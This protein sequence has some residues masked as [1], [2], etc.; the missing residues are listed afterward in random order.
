MNVICDYCGKP[1][2]LVDSTI[3]YGKS[4]GKIYYCARC[5]AWVSCYKNSDRP[6]GRL[7][8]AELR[9]C[10][11]I[12]YAALR[13]FRRNSRKDKKQ[14]RKWLSK[15]LHIPC[16]ET[17]IGLF[18]VEQCRRMIALCKAFKNEEVNVNGNPCSDP[19]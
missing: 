1:A 12:A 18:D 16:A 5:G 7:A 6:S 15:R 19:R 13:D 10:R 8:D 9:K 11:K 3:V 4:Y 14:A 2:P 17:R